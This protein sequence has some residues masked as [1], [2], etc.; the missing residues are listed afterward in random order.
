YAM[1]AADGGLRRL[2]VHAQLARG[3]I[4]VRIRRQIARFDQFAVHPSESADDPCRLLAF[5]EEVVQELERGVPSAVRKHIGKLP[6]RVLAARHDEFL[7]IPRR[8][9]PAAKDVRSKFLEFDM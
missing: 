3:L 5:A 6:D 4:S 1:R 7:D 9:T 8:D 2:R